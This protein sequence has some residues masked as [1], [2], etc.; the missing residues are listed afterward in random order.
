MK[1]SKKPKSFLN[2]IAWAIL[3]AFATL[4]LTAVTNNIYQSVTILA[5]LY[6]VGWAIVRLVRQKTDWNDLK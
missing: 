6:L 3:V 5:V 1:K 2:F 4:I